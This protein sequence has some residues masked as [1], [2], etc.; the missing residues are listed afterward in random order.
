M[1]YDPGTPG[2]QGRRRSARE[3]TNRTR[4]DEG[5]LE[6]TDTTFTDKNLKIN[7]AK[8]KA[9]FFITVYFDYYKKFKLSF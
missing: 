2:D 8:K 1:P 3:Q 6:T 5:W 7:K 4:D 9:D